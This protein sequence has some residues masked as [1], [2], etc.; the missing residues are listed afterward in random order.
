MDLK[1]GYLLLASLT[2]AVI[3]LFYGVNPEWFV[4]T[5]LNSTEPAVDLS[6]I[7]RAVMGLYLALGAF[8]LF[9]AVT[10]RHRSL[11]ILTT[12]I[13]AGGLFAGRLLSIAIDGMPAPLLTF[14]TLLELAILPVAWWL[15]RK[16]E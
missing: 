9:C 1:T 5:F 15:Y 4:G 13:F 8:W 2:V 12:L 6:H 7:L 14:Y 16:P 3:A 10:G 11:A